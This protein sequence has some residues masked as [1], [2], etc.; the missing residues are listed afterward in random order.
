MENNEEKKEEKVSE[1]E[2]KN[3][4]EILNEIKI[5]QDSMKYIPKKY[6]IYFII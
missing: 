1:E 4:T 6:L 5:N 2:I 3:I